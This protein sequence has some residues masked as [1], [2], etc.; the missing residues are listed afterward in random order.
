MDSSPCASRWVSS[1]SCTAGKSSSWYGHAGVTGAMAS[2]GI[3]FPALN[4]VLV[5][6]VE[7]GGGLALLAGVATRAAAALVAFAM[8]VAVMTAHLGQGFFAPAGVEYPL[9]LLLASA[10]LVMTG[11]V[12]SLDAKLFGRRHVEPD[13]WPIAA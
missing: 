11:G 3:P 10:A 4:A 9:T 12:N 8:L 6:A 7:F 13:T 1:S 5:T 2:L